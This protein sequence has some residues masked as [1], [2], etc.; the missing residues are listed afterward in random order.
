M[1]SKHQ[2]LFSKVTDGGDKFSYILLTDCNSHA[3]L[4]KNTNMR[5]H[6]KELQATVMRRRFNN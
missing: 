5:D 6:G 2:V 1:K 4:L 3:Y